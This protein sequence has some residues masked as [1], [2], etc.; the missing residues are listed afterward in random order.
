MVIIITEHLNTPSKTDKLGVHGSLPTQA[1]EVLDKHA[2]SKAKEN[3]DVDHEN[4]L[5]P[6]IVRKVSTPRRSKVRRYTKQ[7]HIDP[8]R[9]NNIDP[10]IFPIRS[11][12][13]RNIPQISG[14]PR[15]CCA[16]GKCTIM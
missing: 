15:N 6:S 14:N 11:T 1:N 9:V 10:A 2:F 5:K 3:E 13:T 7:T 4:L 12:P 8:E 16:G